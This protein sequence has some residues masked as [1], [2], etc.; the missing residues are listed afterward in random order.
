MHMA[1][2]G[3][4]RK[5]LAEQEGSARLADITVFCPGCGERMSAIRTAHF[6]AGYVAPENTCESYSGRC[7]S[8]GCSMANHRLT[9]DFG[10]GGNML[11]WMP[12]PA[13]QICAAAKQ[14]LRDKGTATHN[15]EYR[16][17][18]FKDEALEMRAR[19]W[20]H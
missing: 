8:C 13:H 15:D 4:K 9:S 19:L 3:Q 16:C 6:P 12:R 20:M 1:S 7:T 10:G 18:V 5:V 11:V 14:M 2:S 17:A